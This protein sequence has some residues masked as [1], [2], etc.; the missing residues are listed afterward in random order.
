MKD[1]NTYIKEATREYSDTEK[2]LVNEIG[3]RYKK[4]INSISNEVGT[5]KFNGS[6]ISNILID[7]GNV[8]S[9]D[10]L[11]SFYKKS[12]KIVYPYNLHSEYNNML[13]TANRD[14]YNTFNFYVPFGFVVSI[15]N[16]KE[17]TLI[18]NYNY[19]ATEDLMKSKGDLKNV[20]ILLFKIGDNFSDKKQTK[21]DFVPKNNNQAKNIELATDY[22]IKMFKIDKDDEI[23]EKFNKCLSTFVSNL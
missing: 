18:F 14:N 19:S 21:F 1:L 11:Y 13:V 22:L 8:D 2:K 17:V 4:A 10:T 9:N 15:G 12:H 5:K 16:N 7:N 6:Y 3:K 23:I 20:N